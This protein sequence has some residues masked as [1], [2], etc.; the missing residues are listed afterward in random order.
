MAISEML[1]R[2]QTMTGTK[3][4]M[5]NE[6][7]KFLGKEMVELVREMKKEEKKG[8]RQYFPS[9]TALQWLYICK[10]D[11]RSLSSGVQ[12]ANDYLISLLKKETKNQGI[13]EK[14]MSSIILDSPLYIK[15]LKEYTVY[16]EDRKSVV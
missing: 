3:Q 7:F 13:Y 11:G 1:V 15:S 10:L 9:H 4:P 12:Q 16:K 5:L 8:R 2:L 6:A 14:A